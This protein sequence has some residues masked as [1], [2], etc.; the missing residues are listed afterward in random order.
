MMKSQANTRYIVL[1]LFLYFHIVSP[2]VNKLEILIYLIYMH[3][4]LKWHKVY[5]AFE[6]IFLLLHQRYVFLD[7]KYKNQ[8]TELFLLFGWVHIKRN[9]NQRKYGFVLANAFCI[10]SSYTWRLNLHLN[11]PSKYAFTK[12]NSLFL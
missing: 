9:H 10:T 11:I 7:Q 3:I 6:V 1:F 12:E 5:H 2:I 8:I 4:M